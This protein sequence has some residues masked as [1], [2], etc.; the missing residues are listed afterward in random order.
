MAQLVPLRSGIA[1]ICTWAVLSSVEG[2]AFASNDLPIDRQIHAWF[3]EELSETRLYPR[4]SD[5][6]VRWRV[7]QSVTQ[8][9]SLDNPESNQRSASAGAESVVSQ[10]TLRSRG[11]QRWRLSQDFVGDS[12]S[13]AYLDHVLTPE[14]A[15]KL[16]P[17]WLVLLDPKQPWPAGHSIDAVWT[18]A[19][20]DVSLMM[21]GGLYLAKGWKTEPGDMLQEQERWTCRFDS[22]SDTQSM[23]FE[24]RWDPVAERGFVEALRVTTASKRS[25]VY[26]F[27]GWHFEPAAERWIARSVEYVD[28]RLRYLIELDKV[29]IDPPEVFDNLLKTPDFGAVDGIR[30]VLQI[31]SLTDFRV[32]PPLSRVSTPEGIKEMDHDQL[33]QL[34]R[35][36]RARFRQLGWS[37]CGLVVL[38]IVYQRVRRW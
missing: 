15:W 28:G 9:T 23:V 20:S 18:R 34:E 37:V 26:R 17:I 2:V 10:S 5:L 32:N 12:R 8:P 22:P 35:R 1:C 19:A 13:I 14:Y 38:A 11:P 25:V 21:T 29:W 27:N 30:G 24:G 16:T 33:T 6:V 31:Q 4:V 3:M 36:A 7:T